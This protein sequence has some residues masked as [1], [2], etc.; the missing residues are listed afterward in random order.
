MQRKETSY[1]VKFLA[2]LAIVLALLI[3]A[4]F[5]RR[6]TELLVFFGIAV[7]ISY[8]IGPFVD[9]LEKLR[10]PRSVSIL[11]MY[12]VLFVTVTLAG[13]FLGARIHSEMQQL[14]KQFPKYV[15]VVQ[16]HYDRLM[17]RYHLL[18]NDKTWTETTKKATA[19][20]QK[21]SLNLASSLVRGIFS[22]FSLA[23]G[24]IVVPVLVFYFLKD[25]HIMKRSFLLALPPHWRDN[26]RQ[27][28]DSTNEAVGGF[29]SGQL[30]LCL[31]MGLLMWSSMQFIARLDYAIIMGLIA[32]VTEF[33]PYVG[34][35]LSI[36]LPLI[37]AAFVGVNKIIVVV[38]I[39]LVLQILEGNIL[40]P[41]IMS[42]EVDMHPVII[43]FALMAGGQ[44]AGIAGMIIAL[45]A[46]VMLKVFYDH[47]YIKGYIKP[48]ELA[49]AAAAVHA[50]APQSNATTESSKSDQ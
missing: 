21:F 48:L 12:L 33:I 35:L 10:V 8:L 4:W 45:P 43:I 13:L 30:K 34:P 26:I 31:I 15:K 20:T 29:I 49:T 39:Y 44:V 14:S 25:M 9:R 40:A 16:P 7:V 22:I 5:M 38:V 6:I 36:I 37:I 18:Q 42:K 23:L 11:V 3:V 19:A 28:L 1:A 41:K 32:G 2:C 50:Q 17:E 27:L 24:F 46:A 47:F